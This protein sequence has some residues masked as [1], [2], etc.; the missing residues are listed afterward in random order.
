MLLPSPGGIVDTGG[1][2]SALGFTKNLM[3]NHP[4]EVSPDVLQ[5][6]PF[7]V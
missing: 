7:L 4:E 1:D 3:R 2:S 5:M 6:Q